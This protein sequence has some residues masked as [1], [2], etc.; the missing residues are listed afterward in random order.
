MQHEETIFDK[1]IAR[2]I[3]AAI[4]YEDEDV[5]AFLSI[6]PVHKGHTLV[7]PKKHCRNIFDCPIEDGTRIFAVAQKIARHM[8]GVLGAD[9]INIHM[10]NEEAAGQ[11]VFHL[12]MHVI[13]R[14]ADKH[15]FQHP[16]HETYDEGEMATFA[17][18][19]H[20]V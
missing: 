4:V 13:P 20:L 5:L 11:V 3:P 17:A 18:K 6:E 9:G 14:Y 19:L 2:E 10:N 1:I 15:P 16:T 12:H 8:K 7:I